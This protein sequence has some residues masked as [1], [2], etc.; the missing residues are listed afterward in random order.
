MGKISTEKTGL[1]TENFYATEKG[2]V[3]ERTVNHK[4]ILEHNKKKDEVNI[5][6]LY[7]VSFVVKN[8]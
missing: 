1:L 8:P 6:L 5:I 7:I 2:V 3:Q 4:P